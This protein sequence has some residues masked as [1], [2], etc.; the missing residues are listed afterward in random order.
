MTNDDKIII[1]VGPLNSFAS[2]NF[3][4][5]EG[6]REFSENYSK[7]KQSQ[8]VWNLNK[9][10]QFNIN[11]STLTAFLSIAYRLRKFSNHP[12][13]IVMDWK[14]PVLAFLSD[15]HF[16]NIAKRLDIFMWD[17]RLMGGFKTGET[18][19]NSGIF[20]YS[21]DDYVEKNKLDAWKEWKD[22]LRQ[23]IQ[24]F[25]GSTCENIINP[26]RQAYSFSSKLTNALSNTTTELALN[27]IMHGRETAFI[28]AQRTSNRI[29]VSVCD[30]GVGF[31]NS[32]AK[33]KNIKQL[34]TS[35]LHAIA[36]G[37]IINKREYGLLEAINSVLDYDG[38]VVISSY[39][40]EICFKPPLWEILKNNPI[41]K[42]AESKI[43]E[44]LGREVKKISYNDKQIG[45]W[46]NL[47]KILRGTRITFE[48]PVQ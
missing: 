14:P 4:V 5:S 30:C 33:N 25:V 17:K 16:F 31:K 41:E 2:L 10:E 1:N 12:Q 24:H 11:M 23:D 21:S 43:P 39:D 40:G 32:L 18:N 38:W 45:Y 27:S 48:I 34:I 35:H 6:L 3:H 46:R 9:L 22:D 26:P 15:V 7:G 13:R 42:I 37:S 47:H 44:L 29:T 28:G 20:F 8:I 19:P 36:I